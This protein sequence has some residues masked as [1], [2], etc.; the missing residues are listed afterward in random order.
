MPGETSAR[1]GVP[2]MASAITSDVR[3]VQQDVEAGVT[4]HGPRPRCHI[5][6]LAARCGSIGGGEPGGPGSLHPECR[7]M[8]VTSIPGVHKIGDTSSVT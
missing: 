7:P 1:H 2:H 5:N 4:G 8:V 3:P 6:T